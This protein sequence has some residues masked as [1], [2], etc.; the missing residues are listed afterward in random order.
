[1]QEEKLPCV[2]GLFGTDAAG[3][4]LLHGSRCAG[5]N[6]PYFPRSAA[7]HNP[8]C[9]GS[10]MEDCDFGGRGVL[11][12]Y[13]VADFAP[14]PPHRYDK[15]FVPYAVGVVDLDCGLRMVGQMLDP[16]GSVQVGAAV[17]LVIDTLYHEDGKAFTSWKFRQ[18]A[19]DAGRSH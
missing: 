8:D 18:L 5:C 13:A 15:P 17:E 6:T 9:A 10:R 2:A 19:A 12:S 14:P 1:M 16:P 11:W 3:T 7:C 4:A